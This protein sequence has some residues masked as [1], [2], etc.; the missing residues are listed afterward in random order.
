M[1]DVI[2]G[3]I[4]GGIIGVIGSSIGFIIQGY[5][6]KRTTKMQ[7]DA[8]T[9]E[10]KNQF[11]Y[12]KGQ[13]QIGRLIEVRAQ[14][15]NPLREQITKCYELTGKVV[16][17]VNSISTRYG[18][19]PDPVSRSFSEY[20]LKTT[21]SY[22]D[23]VNKLSKIVAQLSK[24]IKQANLL[25]TK[26]GDHTLRELVLKAYGISL[27]LSID[28]SFLQVASDE[29]QIVT[30]ETI[31]VDLEKTSNNAKILERTLEDVSTHIEE[32]LSG[33]E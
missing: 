13:V 11:E 28:V 33:I 30:N 7:I 4:M 15:L 6:A 25:R 27:M 32:L 23:R 10:Q 26:S 17:E 8:R 5:F 21:D 9:D 24:A 3:I 18:N 29:W 16:E 19:P 14:Y 31:P 12:Q 1:S 20:A 2:I 22:P